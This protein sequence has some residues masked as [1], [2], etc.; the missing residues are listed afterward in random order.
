MTVIKYLFN[1]TVWMWDPHSTESLITGS[2][3]GSP[4]NFIRLTASVD[5]FLILEYTGRGLDPQ[6]LYVGEHAPSNP[7]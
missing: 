4:S 7:P 1:V 3:A 6:R 2:I 5:F